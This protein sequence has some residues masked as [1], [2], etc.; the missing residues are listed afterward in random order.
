MEHKRYQVIEDMFTCL[1]GWVNKFKDEAYLCPQGTEHS[2]SCGSILLGAL[3]K[4]LN[5]I[6]CLNPRPEVPFEGFSFEDLCEKAYAISSPKWTGL[7][8]CRNYCTSVLHSCS[9][10]RTVL[11]D[12][13]SFDSEVRGL[14]LREFKDRYAEQ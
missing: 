13:R 2:F 5:R 3:L 10:D 11:Q 1:H 9:F 12:A 7:H 8:S 6:E 4:E 14:S